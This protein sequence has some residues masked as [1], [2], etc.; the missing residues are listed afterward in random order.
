MPDP[1]TDL[2]DASHAELRALVE[3]HPDDSIGQLADSILAARGE[4]KGD[5]RQTNP[6]VDAPKPA[7]PE[8]E[9]MS[10][11]TPDDE[12][13]TEQRETTAEPNPWAE[14][15]PALAHDDV[16]EA[17][18]GLEDTLREIE[19]TLRAGDT[20]TAEQVNELREE[21]H[22]LQAFTEQTL[23]VVADGTEPWARGLN[24]RVS[25]GTLREQAVT[26]GGDR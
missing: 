20:P 9:P 18:F 26:P 12:T 15:G 22:G 13:T 6:G 8:L 25:I 11:D 23:A 16:M 17:R 21:L 5:D 24:Q 7:D 10:N 19:A 14:V 2:T 4:E 1:P 3:E